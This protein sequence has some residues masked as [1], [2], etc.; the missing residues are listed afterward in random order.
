[1]LPGKLRL[2]KIGPRTILVVEDQAIA[3][4]TIRRQLE[5]YKYEVVEGA[6]GAQGLQV[7]QQ[8]QSYIDLVL[9]DLS[10]PDIPAEQVLARL[11][12]LDPEVKVVVCTEQTL[13]EGRPELKDVV[14]VLRK[15]IRTDR[16]LALLHL[17]LGQ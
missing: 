5:Y 8:K 11:R 15:P 10:L 4:S 3:R 12:A 1:M 13:A 9:L 17:A 6:T 14:G 2:P 16:L 7:F